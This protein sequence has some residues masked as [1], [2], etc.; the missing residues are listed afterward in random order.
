MHSV[1]SFRMT[2]LFFALSG[3]DLMDALNLS[4]ENKKDIINWIYA[5]QILPNDDGIEF[6]FKYIFRP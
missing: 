2:V 4:D 5:Q 3:L 1:Y 6:I